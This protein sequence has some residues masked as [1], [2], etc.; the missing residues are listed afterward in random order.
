[1]T[2]HYIEVV[3]GLQP[4]YHGETLDVIAERALASDGNEGAE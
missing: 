1:M 2:L 4:G 3:K